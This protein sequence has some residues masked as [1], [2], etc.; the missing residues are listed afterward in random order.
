MILLR[1]SLFLALALGV[2]GPAGWAKA[3]PKPLTVAQVEARNETF[4]PSFSGQA[5]EARRLTSFLLDALILSTAQCR[6]LQACTVAE[7]AALALAITD[8]DV[9]Q[10]RRQYQLAVHQV[11]APS[12][13]HLYGV[14]YRQLAGTMMPLDGPE[15]A[16]RGGR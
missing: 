8:G 5:R 1:K 14:L 15:L 9:V 3:T 2:A 4:A 11:L 7:C 13:A 6:A 16:G 12:Q 10:A